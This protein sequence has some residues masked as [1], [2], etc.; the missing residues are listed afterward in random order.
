MQSD[1]K[2]IYKIT[3]ARTGKS[4]Q[5]YK[6]IGNFV[7]KSVIDNIKKPK[8][9]IITLKGIGYWFL[10][11]H[12]IDRM[13]SYYPPYYE[14]EG[15]T[16][17]ISERAFLNFVNKKEMYDI[18]KARQKDYEKYIHLR[19]ETKKKKNEHKRLR[20]AQKDGDQSGQNQSEEHSSSPSGLV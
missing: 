12:R 7:Q 2:Q 3:A 4:E 11:K 9:L 16:D 20:K 15:H 10:R 6:D 17:F 5:L 1:S 19:E 18:F 8:T 13:L 14:L